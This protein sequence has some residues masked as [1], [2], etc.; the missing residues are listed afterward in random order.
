M[1]STDRRLI[2][3][4]AINAAFESGQ[5]YWSKPF[6]LDDLQRII[7]NS[8][9]FG[10]YEM[11]GATGHDPEGELIQVGFA[12]VVTDYTTVAYGTDYYVLPEYHQLGLGEW[13]IDCFVEVLD[14]LEG[15]MDRSVRGL[16]VVTLA[17]ERMIKWYEEKTGM[18]RAVNGEGD[19]WYLHRTSEMLK[20]WRNKDQVKQKL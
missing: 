8:L 16:R 2:Q 12:R 9:C 7:D 1:V 3:L 10:L 17:K 15:S 14:M 5:I 6:K 20:D 4:E 19:L 11:V 18:K 13:L